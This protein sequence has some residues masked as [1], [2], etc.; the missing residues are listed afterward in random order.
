MNSSLRI[1]SYIIVISV[2]FLIRIAIDIAKCGRRLIK[3]VVL[4]SGSI[5]Y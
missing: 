5:I 4:F 1:G 3:L 2:R